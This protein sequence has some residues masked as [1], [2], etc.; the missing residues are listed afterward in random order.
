[1]KQTKVTTMKRKPECKVE[2]EGLSGVEK[3]LGVK[4]GYRILTCRDNEVC[5]ECKEA[6]KWMYLQK[7][8]LPAHDG[9][10]CHASKIMW[11]KDSKHKGMWHGCKG[12]KE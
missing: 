4:Y 3:I 7:P 10:R 12:V 11:T 8:T 9:C 5:S 2:A 6:S 1:M